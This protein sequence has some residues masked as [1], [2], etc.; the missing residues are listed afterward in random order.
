MAA[1]FNAPAAG[2]A[3]APTFVQAEPL[4]LSAISA[5]VNILKT[6]YPI[7]R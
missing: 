6:D 2:K 3:A 5:R 4:H 1:A 7:F